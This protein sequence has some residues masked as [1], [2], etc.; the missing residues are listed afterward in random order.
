MNGKSREELVEQYEDAALALLMNEYAEQEGNRLLQE[1]EAAKPKGQVPEIPAALDIRC[2]TLIRKAYEK[3][4]RKDRMCRFLRTFGRTITVLLAALGL[5]ATLVFS[6]DAVRIPVVNFLINHKEGFMVISDNH[7]DEQKPHFDRNNPLSGVIPADYS[8]EKFADLNN[9]FTALYLNGSKDKIVLTETLSS[10]SLTVNTEYTEY[11][12]ELKIADY[13]AIFTK[14]DTISLVWIS[15]EEEITFALIA[16]ALT[17]KEMVTIAENFMQ[18][19]STD[20]SHTI[21]IAPT[22]GNKPNIS[23]AT[24]GNFSLDPFVPADFTLSRSTIKADGTLNIVYKNPAGSSIVFSSVVLEG[25]LGLDT[26]AATV[27]IIKI[28]GYHGI[29]VQKE[30]ILKAIWFDEE[31]QLSYLLTATDVDFASFWRMA[32]RIAAHDWS[33]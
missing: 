15:P 21:I 16:D 25:N 20:S 32:E 13:D 26:Q 18:I 7:N 14:A 19:R 24:N 22:Q 17:E 9:G 10:S 8:L 23:G 29:L 6:V 28:A 27:E 33:E 5:C 11:T 30:G 3:Q 12:K 1:F 4:R 2:R 31:N